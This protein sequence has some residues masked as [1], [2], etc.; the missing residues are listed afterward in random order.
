VA[1]TIKA[2]KGGCKKHTIDDRGHLTQ[3]LEPCHAVPY[4]TTGLDCTCTQDTMQA[5][6][7]VH[8]VYC[9]RLTWLKPYVTS[10][11]HD[12]RTHMIATRSP[13]YMIAETTALSPETVQLCGPRG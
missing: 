12:S 7:G 4:H 1:R 9:S 10:V 5:S 2:H 8:S 11:G 13:L 6:T 3:L